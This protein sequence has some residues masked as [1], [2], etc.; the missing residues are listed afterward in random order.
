M[1][2]KNY[3]SE[4]LL[5]RSRSRRFLTGVFDSLLPFLESRVRERRDRERERPKK[6]RK[7]QLVNSS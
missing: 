7:Q 4:R 3:L 2:S 1:Y 5:E 6:N